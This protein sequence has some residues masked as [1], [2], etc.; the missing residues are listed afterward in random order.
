MKHSPDF[1][2]RVWLP[3]GIIWVGF[4]LLV[5]YSSA[6]AQT[7]DQCTTTPALGNPANIII[8][9][10]QC[11]LQIEA[12][13]RSALENNFLTHLSAA[14]AEAK[15]A[16]GKV[17]RLAVEGNLKDK[18]AKDRE[19]YWKSYLAGLDIQ[20]ANTRRFYSELSYYMQSVCSWRGVQNEPTAKMCQWW[21]SH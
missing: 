4:I 16:E 19:V 3:L 18:T 6:H 20:A 13:D 11:Q 2:W 17:N 10:L 14:E 12:E 9:K 8:Q 5:I 21:H 15:I 1:W 7:I